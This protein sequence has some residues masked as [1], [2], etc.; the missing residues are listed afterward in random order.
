MTTSK[1]CF[2]Q[3]FYHSAW[4]WWWLYVLLLLSSWKAFIQFWKLVNSI[5]TAT[6]KITPVTLS[7]VSMI[8]HLMRQL[9]H[10]FAV[11]SS[12]GFCEQKW[13]S[14]NFFFYFVLYLFRVIVTQLKSR[15]NG[16]FFFKGRSSINLA[17]DRLKKKEE[18]LI[19]T[20]L[21]VDWIGT[22]RLL[23][24]DST[25]HQTELFSW[26]TNLFLTLK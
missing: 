19:S 8:C 7:L 23:N 25:M 20:L 13:K 2:R 6:N 24:V 18:F 17:T 10:F 15:K 11:F 9:Q 16:T 4:W 26:K 14:L 3:S 5:N 22:K 1:C 21:R 12:A